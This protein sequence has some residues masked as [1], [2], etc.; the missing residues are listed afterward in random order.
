M[1][2]R[3]FSLS[4]RRDQLTL[5]SFLSYLL[6]SLPSTFGGGAPDLGKTIPHP[7]SAAMYRSEKLAN[8]KKCM[9]EN[10]G[11]R[12]HHN[13]GG[14]D[15]RRLEDKRLSACRATDDLVQMLLC[16]REGLPAMRASCQH[17]LTVPGVSGTS[18]R[19]D[20]VR[21]TMLSSR[22]FRLW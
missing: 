6:G 22:V 11:A 19:E 15:G 8:R 20:E 2:S 21:R 7:R 10:I 1:L 17:D 18:K 14:L 4:L 12:R 3:A 9:T 5:F 13:R 16:D